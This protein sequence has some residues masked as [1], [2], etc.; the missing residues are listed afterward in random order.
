MTPL[1]PDS[2]REKN[3]NYAILSA[4]YNQVCI[5]MYVFINM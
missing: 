1:D 5:E 3:S 4:Y 2:N